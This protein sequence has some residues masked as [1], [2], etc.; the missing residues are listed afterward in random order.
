MKLPQLH[1]SVILIDSEFLISKINECY[2]FYSDLYPDREFPKLE[3]SDVIDSI[4]STSKITNG[5]DE[6]NVLFLYRI[7]ND[8]L[9]YTSEPNNLFLFND[10]T[11]KPITCTINN[12]RYDVASFY[13]D[14]E[15]DDDFEYMEEFSQLLRQIS[16]DDA[17]FNIC[18]V[19]DNNYYNYFLET[20]EEMLDKAFFVFR[21]TDYEIGIDQSPKFHYVNFDYVLASCMGLKQSEW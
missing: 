19:A 21:G 20:F 4:A 7:N 5:S 10:F 18:L 9:P 15:T 14:P 2:D 3:L 12:C 13:S 8:A 1:E 11:N 6:I 17:T 16:Y